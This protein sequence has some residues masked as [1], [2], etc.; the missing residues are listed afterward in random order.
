MVGPREVVEGGIMRAVFKIKYVVKVRAV[1]F[2]LRAYHPLH[3]HHHDE[4][5]ADHGIKV[6]YWDGQ[7]KLQKVKKSKFG[8]KGHLLI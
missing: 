6:P 7:N 3:H 2:F 1:F 4:T 5:L 8:A